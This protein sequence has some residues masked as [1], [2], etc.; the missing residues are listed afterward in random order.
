M[1]MDMKCSHIMC[2]YMNDIVDSGCLV[3]AHCVGIGS[4]IQVK[5]KKSHILR[6]R[7]HV[8]LSF[9]PNLNCSI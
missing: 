7:V 2:G 9:A 1:L 6:V 3:V 5:A 8:F 4:A